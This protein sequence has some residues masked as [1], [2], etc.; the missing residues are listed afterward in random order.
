MAE[1]RTEILSVINK[2][3]K[4]GETLAN[5]TLRH[6]WL[7]ADILK[8]KRCIKEN[9]LQEVSIT[10]FGI[11]GLQN[12]NIPFCTGRGNLGIADNFQ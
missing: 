7:K 2:W 5:Y 1:T 9:N 12:G 11:Y 6:G 10:D 3:K 4:N 8:L